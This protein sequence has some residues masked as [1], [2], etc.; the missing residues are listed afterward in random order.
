MKDMDFVKTQ[1]VVQSIYHFAQQLDQVT[2][3]IED[4][5]L[6][7]RVVGEF[8]AGKTR[9]IREILKDKIPEP[10]LPISS[11]EAQTKLQLEISYG[12]QDQLFLIE[13]PED[14]RT[15]IKSK[16]FV[17]MYKSM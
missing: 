9:V 7:I 12:E 13:K 5:V 11:Q 17:P 1:L 2:P 10:F 14:I 3:K 4:G 8:S 16:M 6:T 15:F